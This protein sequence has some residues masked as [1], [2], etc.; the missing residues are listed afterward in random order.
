[1][2]RTALQYAT[3]G[4]VDHIDAD[5]LDWHTL[6]F[7]SEGHRILWLLRDVALSPAFRQVGE[8]E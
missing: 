3:G 6:G 1:M 5:L 4:L 7:E 8:V 2:T